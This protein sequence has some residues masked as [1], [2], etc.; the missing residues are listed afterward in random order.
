M[1][2]SDGHPFEG[3]WSGD[4]N[5]NFDNVDSFFLFFFNY[6]KTCFD[7]FSPVLATYYL[8]FSPYIDKAKKF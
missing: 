2:V 5:F 4:I 1:F 8:K 7:A 6:I 3:G